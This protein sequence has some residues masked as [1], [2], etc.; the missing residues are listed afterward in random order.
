MM[1]PLKCCKYSTERQNIQLLEWFFLH[2]S[3]YGIKHVKSAP[4]YK[5]V[6]NA[7][8]THD[9]DRI[10]KGFPPDSNKQENSG[11]TE[12]VNDLMI[13]VWLLAP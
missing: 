1:P 9:D 2:I 8:C 5:N 13:Q 3:R 4:L 12:L 7:W 10:A 11:L 6:L